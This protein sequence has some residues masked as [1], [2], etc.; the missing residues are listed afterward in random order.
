[1]FLNEM[2]DDDLA[3]LTEIGEPTHQTAG[4]V[5][6][7]EGTEGPD[8]YILLSGRAAVVGAG[9]VLAHLAPGDVAG[10]ISL[11]DGMPASATVIL[12][13]PAQVLRINRAALMV[14]LES[15]DGLAFRFHRAVAR[16]LASRLRGSNQRAAMKPEVAR[17]LN[18]LKAA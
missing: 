11:I 13:A 15:G 4:T 7:S 14:R 9:A 5:L 1:M 2:T 16:V 18:Q 8:V 6:I 3:W 10:E 12:T 17:M